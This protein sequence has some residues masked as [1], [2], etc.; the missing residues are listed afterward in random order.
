MDTHTYYSFKLLLGTLF[1]DGD[2]YPCG[3]IVTCLVGNYPTIK[4]VG[5][6][7]QG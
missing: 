6:D 1:K 2:I 4:H 5:L 7:N 3:Q